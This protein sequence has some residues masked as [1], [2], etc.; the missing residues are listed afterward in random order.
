MSSPR[1]RQARR[2]RARRRRARATLVAVTLL[3]VAVSIAGVRVAGRTDGADER[4][5]RPQ[6]AGKSFATNEPI[7]RACAVEPRLLRR[8]NRGYHRERSEDLTILPREPNYVGGFN[9]T[10]HSG[11]WDYLQQIPLVVYGPMHIVAS[12]APVEARAQIADVAPT[13]GELTDVELPRRDGS[14]LADALRDDRSSPPRLVVTMV[15]DG[16]GRNTLTRWPDRWPTLARLEREGTSF[17]NA[18]VGSSPSITSAVHTTLGTGALPRTHGITGNSIRLPDGSLKKTFSQHVSTDV[19]LS[20][21]AD[22]IDLAYGNEPKVGLLGWKNWHLG[23]LGH[24]AEIPGGDLDEVVVLKYDDGIEYI[25]DE[26]FFSIP[27]VRPQQNVEDYV[28][29]LDRGDG[30]VDNEWMGHDVS[31]DSVDW[32]TNSNPAWAEFQT[33]LMISMLER[34]EY[35]RDDVPDLFF[36]NFKGTDLAAHQW[37]VDGPETG[38]VLEAQD[39]ALQ[40]LI[41][42]LDENV[43]DY[44]V[45]LTADHGAAPTPSD[46]GAWPIGQGELI[47]DVNAHFEVPEN[48]SLFAVTAAFGYYLDLELMREL[49][50]TSYDIAEFLNGYTIRENARGSQLP[51]EYRGRGD[52]QIFSAVFP[53]KRLDKIMACAA[54]RNG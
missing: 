42:Y 48:R 51:E 41:D 46:S 38:E 23:M 20:T 16:A 24:G 12:G 40:E 52:E 53:T 31:L 22:D 8:I 37:G 4:R 39:A 43:G 29:A 9:L 44:V 33:D 45:V 32:A 26:S 2:L 54:E 50:V 49:G 3:A 27:Y 13:A 11:P 14:V 35:G 28:A 17:R 25:A 1:V 19:L 5:E 36:T 6:P 10:S 21:F 15:W 34:G 47:A 18:T 7:E 30:K